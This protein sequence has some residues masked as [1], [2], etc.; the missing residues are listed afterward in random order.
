MAFHDKCYSRTLR[1]DKEEGGAT[2]FVSEGIVGSPFFKFVGGLTRE[3]AG[4]LGDIFLAVQRSVIITVQASIRETLG[5]N[6]TQR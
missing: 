3:Q 6:D 5:I 1:I 2:W 4:T